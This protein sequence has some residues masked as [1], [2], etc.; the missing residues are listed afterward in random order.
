MAVKLNGAGRSHAASLIAD[1]KVDKDSSWS[2]SAEDENKLLGDNNWS[3]YGKW[4]LAVDD[5]A[6]KETKGHFKYPFGKDGK[7]FRRAVIAIKSRA[8]QQGATEIESAADALLKKID[9][10]DKQEKREEKRTFDTEFKVETRGE[11]MGKKSNTLSG[12]AAKFNTLSEPMPIMHEGEQIGMFREQLMPNC[13]ASAVNTSDIRALINHDPNLILG[14]TKSG[15]L[16]ISQDDVGLRFENDLPETSYAKD[17]Q[18]SASR[19]DINQCSFG[20]SV[21]PGGDTYSKDSENP[22]WYIRSINNVG[23][24]YDVSAVTYPAYVDT[25]CAVRSLVNF[26]HAEKDEVELRVAERLEE[27]R[28]AKEI[29]EQEE[30]EAR[31]AQEAEEQRIAAEQAE[32]ERKLQMEKDQEEK[33]RLRLFELS[34]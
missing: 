32:E 7:V 5:S 8:A 2:M 13:F 31:E 10:P 1:G 34:L 18:I 11:G 33:D 25:D 17:L 26:I 29:K 16:R 20:F 3:E 4:F 14:R 19:G 27:E 28:V 23:K 15:T 24:L 30:R 6:D 9:G 21:A 22:G 12:Y